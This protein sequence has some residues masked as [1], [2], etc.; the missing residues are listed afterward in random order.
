MSKNKSVYR[1]IISSEG[2]KMKKEK[3][4]LEILKRSSYIA[5]AAIAFATPAIAAIVNTV[6]VNGNGPAGALPPVTKDEEVDVQDH[7]RSVT[8]VKSWTF[9]PGGDANNNGLVDAGDNIVFSYLVTNNGNVTLSDVVQ[10]DSLFDGTGTAPTILVPTV[11]TTDGGP[12][13]GDS[14][15]PTTG[16]SD[17]DTLGPG[18]AIT[19][20]ST[21]YTVTAA[22]IATAGGGDSD[23]DTTGSV[24]GNYNP[25]TGNLTT[26]AT[27][28][29]AVPLNVTP[30]L[31]VDK[32]ADD[33][34][35][36]VAGQVITYTYTVSNNGNV[37][38]TS[39]TLSDT[40]NGVVGGLTPTFASWTTQNGSVVAGNTITTLNPGAV[41]V[42]TATYT[43]TQNDIDTRQ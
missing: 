13:T 39:I 17:W 12:S 14:V 30:L 16:D 28:P 29:E 31:V 20:T 25:G 6:T 10:A 11:V 37:P 9:A 15:D 34:T 24:T 19:Y 5:L 3:T 22:D 32:I 42:F 23:I 40:H 1:S 2:T 41:A 33:T 36:V 35:D 21:P 27:D 43:V 26:N 18:D 8:L 38:L 7:A 4:K